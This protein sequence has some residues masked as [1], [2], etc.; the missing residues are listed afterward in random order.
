MSVIALGLN[1]ST[2]PLDLR[3]RFAFA[4]EQLG[5]ALHGF[6]QRIGHRALPEAAL[7]S[8][9][10]RTELYFAAG[11]GHSHELVRPAIDWLADVHNNAPKRRGSW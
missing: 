2:A 6:R 10:N 1:H 3:G 9:C 11:T 4:P 5:S 7:L 8:T